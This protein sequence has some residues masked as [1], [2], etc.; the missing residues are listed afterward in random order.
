[1]DGGLD[2]TLCS[3]EEALAGRNLSSLVAAPSRQRSALR[4]QPGRSLEIGG[5][6]KD[7]VRG[8]QSNPRFLAGRPTQH[9][10]RIRIQ[11]LQVI[12]LD[13]LLLLSRV[14]NPG[15]SA[16]RMA[17]ASW[18]RITCRRNRRRAGAGHLRASARSFAPG[19]SNRGLPV[20][21][22]GHWAEN[23]RLAASGRVIITCMT[24]RLPRTATIPPGGH[25]A[26]AAAIRGWRSELEAD[27]RRRSGGDR[28]LGAISSRAKSREAFLIQYGKV[29]RS[30]DGGTSWQLFPSE[31][32]ENSSVHTLWLSAD[33]SGAHGCFERRPRRPGF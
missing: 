11:S 25:L 26:R 21:L 23:W 10:G 13:K 3:N 8:L 4:R 32:L 31:G 22:R 17:G 18:E 2:W 15:S 6:W 5:R 14:R 27:H 30:L 9:F 7:L 19:R 16:V 33:I 20:F 29:Y 24:W 28:K 12:Q 1:M